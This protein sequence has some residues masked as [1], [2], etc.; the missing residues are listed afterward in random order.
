MYDAVTVSEIPADAQAVAGYT[1]GNF[2]T[3][4]ELLKRFPHA[5]RLSI[6]INAGHDADCLDVEPGDATPAD[7]AVWVKRQQARGVA[8]PVLYASVSTMP[9]VLRELAAAGIHREHVRLWTAHYTGRAH[10]CSPACGFGF[11]ETADATQWT[12][13]AL[14]RNLD[15]SLCADTFFATAH[16]AAGDH[17]RYDWFPV[18]PFPIAGRAL[19]ERAVV[20]EYDRLRPHAFFHARTLRR[21]RV[22]LAQLASRVL[23]VAHEH[24]N[25][26]GTPSWVAERRGWRYQQLTHRAH[27]DR[28]A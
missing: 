23:T 4:P 19:N 22:E 20:Q 9:T 28:V 3:W 25:Q 14:G 6:A 26:D 1:S 17:L 8:R 24:P 27:G 12:D 13:K 18:G 21:L 15:E 2:P 16:P 10:L 7:A 11:L 5:H